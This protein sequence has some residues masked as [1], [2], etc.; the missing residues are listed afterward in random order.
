MVQILHKRQQKNPGTAEVLSK[1]S[2]I[3]NIPI[4]PLPSYPPSHSHIIYLRNSA[5]SPKSA[6]LFQPYL[7]Q[8]LIQIFTG[9]CIF[10]RFG[11]LCVDAAVEGGEAHVAFG[12]KEKGYGEA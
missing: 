2:I 11:V 1:R 3:S 9:R 4:I 8:P 6:L 12:V 7:P 5:P 10:I